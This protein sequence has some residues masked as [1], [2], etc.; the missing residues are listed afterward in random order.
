[1]NS[2]K[3][4]IDSIKAAMWNYAQKESFFRSSESL[5]DE[6][7]IEYMKDP[8]KNKYNFEFFERLISDEDIE[9]RFK[10]LEQTILDSSDSK[11]GI[12]QTKTAKIIPFKQRYDNASPI[13]IHRKAAASETEEKIR[14]PVRTKHIQEG[15][16][17]IN[18]TTG[19]LSGYFVLEKPFQVLTLVLPNEQ[20]IDVTDKEEDAVVFKDFKLESPIILENI[21]YEFS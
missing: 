13:V 9:K 12:K 14:I 10:K 6:E 17:W 16:L 1:M 11:G 2:D 21:R 20:T 7:L 5:S 4:W 18:L 3:S 8:E 15:E 19:N